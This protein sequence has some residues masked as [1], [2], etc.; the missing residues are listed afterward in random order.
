M[1]ECIH[2]MKDAAYVPICLVGVGLLTPNG[3]GVAIHHPLKT[4]GEEMTGAIIWYESREKMEEA[5]HRALSTQHPGAGT[6]LI[7]R[8][9]RYS[10]A[11][12]AIQALL[13]SRT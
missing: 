7:V 2:Q 8:V 10:S 12:L 13:E 11:Q 4:P 3:F 6:D 9:D 1:L 5:F